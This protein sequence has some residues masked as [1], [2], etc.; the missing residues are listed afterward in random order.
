MVLPATV[1]PKSKPVVGSDGTLNQQYEDIDHALTD[2]HSGYEADRHVGTAF[3][4]EPISQA[5]SPSLKPVDSVGI[6]MFLKRST[7][8]NLLLTE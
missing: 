7:T 8:Y 4:T 1:E 6:R 5:T 3:S 2:E